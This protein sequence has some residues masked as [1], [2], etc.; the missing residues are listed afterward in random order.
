MLLKCSRHG[1]L[2]LEP[3]GGFERYLVVAPEKSHVE[4]RQK[5]QER[6]FEAAGQVRCHRDADEHH[7]HFARAREHPVEALRTQILFRIKTRGWAQTETVTP[8][9]YYLSA[10]VSSGE[11]K[12]AERHE[13]TAQSNFAVDERAQFPHV[14][15]T[16][17]PR[18][19]M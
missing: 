18:N 12:D 19:E 15:N 10:Q 6:A 14:A 17:L 11:Q 5:Q 13:P 16:L 2:P 4:G 8:H 3:A 9:S 1:S 7:R